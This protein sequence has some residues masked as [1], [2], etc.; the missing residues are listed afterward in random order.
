M[1]ELLRREVP[2]VL[3]AARALPAEAHL[4]V[5]LA[6]VRAASARGY[7]LPDE[8]ESVRLRYMQYLALRASL[9]GSMSAL[10]AAADRHGW[11][12][13]LP[14]FATA[15]AAACVLARAARFMSG[16]ALE[17]PVLWKKLDEADSR[18]GLPRKSFTR[19][20]KESVSPVTLARFRAAAEFYG[21][22]RSEIHALAADPALAPVVGLLGSEEP[23]IEAGRRAAVRRHFL[24]RIFSFRRRH[25]SAWRQVMFGLFE[26]G[27]RAVSDLHLPGI[28]PAGAP[29]RVTPELRAALAPHLRPG[30]VVVTRHDD[31]VSNLFLPGFWP[32]AVLHLGSAEERAAL[33]IESP[34]HG[35]GEVRFLESKKDGVRFRPM[36]ETLEVDACV[37]LRPPLE[38]EGLATAIRRAMSHEGKLYDFLFDFRSA[39]RL[40]CTAVIYRGF[41]GVGPVAFR[42]KEVSGR[43]CLPAEDLLDQALGC[44]FRVVATCGIGGNSLLLGAPAEEAFRATRKG[45]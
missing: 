1:D 32:H 5:E 30:D 29:K 2:V 11:E 6:H 36:D 37:V 15:F 23:R 40:A 13:G 33:G 21:T 19:A 12:E 7:F 8:D 38:G 10:A 17:H 44:G 16:V 43:L 25:R 41:D 28:K 35:R 18:L 34:A 4:A 31:A 45:A 22:H 14:A 3:A 42:L 26:T 27:G 20:Y 39:D 9:L 24:Y